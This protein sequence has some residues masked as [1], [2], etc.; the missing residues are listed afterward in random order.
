MTKL[1]DEFGQE[2]ES[3]A[4][5]WLSFLA[6]TAPLLGLLGTVFGIHQV[7]LDIQGQD[8]ISAEVVAPGFRVALE[9]TALGLL[10]TFVA[11]GFIEFLRLLKRLVCRAM[12]GNR[13]GLRTTGESDKT[14]G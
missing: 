14:V 10:I 5:L 9:T 8:A 11:L 1:C 13:Q 7:F 3:G 4:V 2:L 12:T 6:Q